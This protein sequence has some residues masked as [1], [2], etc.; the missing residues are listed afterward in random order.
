MLLDKLRKLCNVIWPNH[1]K[2]LALK[3]QCYSY[4]YRTQRDYIVHE[5]SLVKILILRTCYDSHFQYCSY[6]G[7]YRPQI[8]MMRLLFQLLH[9]FFQQIAPLTQLSSVCSCISALH[10]PLHF[11]AIKNSKL[12][13]WGFISLSMWSNVQ[14]FCHLPV[15]PVQTNKGVH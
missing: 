4:F 11:S 6:S 15:S 5:Q 9:H 14:A 8:W 1:T 10:E 2:S 13:H 3:Q 12:I 7:L